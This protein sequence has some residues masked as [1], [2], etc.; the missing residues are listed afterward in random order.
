[1]N[2]S[3]KPIYFFSDAHLGAGSTEQERI[4]IRKL[5]EL[6][7]RIGHE[8]ARCFIL[9][10][11]FDFWFEFRRDIPKGYDEILELLRATTDRG[12]DIHFI[13]GNH[14]WWAGEKLAA[15]TGLVIHK[16]PFIGELAGLR[17]YAG[18]GD[19]LARSD[20]G[21]RNIL[22]PILRNRVNVWLFRQLPRVVGQSLARMVSGGSRIYTKQRNLRMDAEYVEAARDMCEDNL[23]I[24]V[25]GHT[26]EPARIVEFEKGRYIN[27]G[28]FYEQFSYGVLMNGDF[29]L[30]RI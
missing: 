1:M 24:V 5:A 25:I 16:E 30:M 28:E 13:G 9:G 8:Q 12:A 6:L 21:Y 17:I 3:E 29:V 7:D 26:H 15:L 4:K 18:H 11:L 20:R 27:I 23:D 10:D 22:R 19:G 14:D 2:S